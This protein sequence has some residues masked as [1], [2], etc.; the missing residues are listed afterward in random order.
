MMSRLS[1]CSV[2]TVNPVYSDS[3]QERLSLTAAL[4][5]PAML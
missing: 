1:A 5:M 3:S 2:I 4:M